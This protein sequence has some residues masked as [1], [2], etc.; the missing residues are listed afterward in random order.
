[1]GSRSRFTLLLLLA[2]AAG[3]DSSSTPTAPSGSGLQVVAA[4]AVLRSGETMP[5]TVTGTT[6]GSPVTWST[7]DSTVL[8]VSPTGIVTAGRAGRATV[9]ATSG[10]ASGSLA[11]RVATDY[12]GTWTGGVLHLQVTCEPGSA[13][14]VCVPGA[15]TGATLTLTLTQTGDQVTGTLEDSLEPTATV[16]VTGQVLETDEL[17]LAGRVET[18]ATAPTL[19]VDVSSLR[20]TMDVARTVL[21]GNF[22][23]AVDRRTG[24]STAL[25]S[26]Y[27]AQAQF[28]DLRRATAVTP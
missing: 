3:C 24:A 19:R 6:A 14:P 11:L 23:L 4:R 2:F 13:A 20:A 18:P 21:N 7:S 26:D 5:L 16:P 28:R 1:M 12:A 27:R 17:S 22:S 8:A 10:N 15:P 25:A 9:S